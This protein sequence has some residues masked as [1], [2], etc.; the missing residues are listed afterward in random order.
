MD[1]AAD[2]AFIERREGIL[3]VLRRHEARKPG[4]GALLFL[5]TPLRRPRFPGDGNLV[6]ARL[7]RC[8]GRRVDRIHHRC[9]NCS[10]TTDDASIVFFART[11]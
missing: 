8:A 4:R 1:F 10:I 3:R 7:V 6:Q 11:E 5:R 9:V 2:I